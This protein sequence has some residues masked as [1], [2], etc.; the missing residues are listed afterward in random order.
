VY[1]ALLHTA[2]NDSAVADEYRGLIDALAGEAA[3]GI[4]RAQR[5]GVMRDVPAKETAMS[6]T[7]MAERAAVQMLGHGTS[8]EKFGDTMADIMWQTLYVTTPGKMPAK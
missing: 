7:W 4:R 3:K 1:A 8:A 5:A 2:A 6:F